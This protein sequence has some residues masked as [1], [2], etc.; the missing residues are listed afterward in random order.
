MEFFIHANGVDG[1]LNAANLRDGFLVEK[2]EILQ[3]VENFNAFS[4]IRHKPDASIE[5]RAE[6]QLLE[7][8]RQCS[9]KT[10][11]RHA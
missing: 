3:L 2:E 4:R 1:F 5:F 10:K 11:G 7:F 6:I 9:D 8:I